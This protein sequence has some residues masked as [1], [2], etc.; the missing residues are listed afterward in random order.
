MCQARYLTN[1]TALTTVTINAREEHDY[2]PPEAPGF[3]SANVAASW[4]VVVHVAAQD[5]T[6]NSYLV[7]AVLRRR[8]SLVWAVIL[9]PGLALAR[10]S[11]HP[12]I[13][14]PPALRYPGRI[15]R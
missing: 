9:L 13:P 1:R 14:R 4:T 5:V 15:K 7:G 6:E 12:I 8:G 2:K 3:T 11:L 10:A